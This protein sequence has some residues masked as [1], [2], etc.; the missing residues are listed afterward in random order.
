NA[1]FG[2]RD[3]NDVL[4]ILKIGM[5]IPAFDGENVGVE[6]WSRGGM[7]TYQ[8]LT[9]LNFLKCAIVVAG[10]AD[11]RGNF[12]RYNWLKDKFYGM[13]EGAD[14]KKINE[15]IEKRSAVEFYKKI[16]TE[17]PLLLIHGNA[18]NKISYEDSVS[19]Y[20]KL[21]EF[22][23]AEL[24]LETIEN[25]DHYLRKNRSEVRKLRRSWFNKYLQLNN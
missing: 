22:K 12:K 19:M 15:E 10:L 14:E 1:E 7:M 21:S 17:V 5:S 20:K 9:K 2:G 24:K 23:R 3:I 25:G 16:H 4:N 8:L 6:G 11:L 18:D 13:F